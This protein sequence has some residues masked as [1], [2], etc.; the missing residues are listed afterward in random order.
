MMLYILIVPDL[1]LHRG[2]KRNGPTVRWNTG[3]GV[4]GRK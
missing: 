1:T 4:E 3:L 2:V